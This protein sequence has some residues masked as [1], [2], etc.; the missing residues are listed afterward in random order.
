MFKEFIHILRTYFITFRY[1]KK[2]EINIIKNLLN[3][4]IFFYLFN[5]I[6]LINYFIIIYPL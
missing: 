5:F 3:L 6:V 2:Y 4:I 1:I